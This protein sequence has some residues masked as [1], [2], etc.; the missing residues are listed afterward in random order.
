MKRILVIDDDSVM[1]QY[2]SLVLSENKYLVQSAST[3]KEGIKAAKEISPDLIICDVLLPDIDGFHVIKELQKQQLTKNVPVIFISA[4]KTEIDDIR[5]A[6]ELGADDYLI[7]P[8]KPEEILKSVEVRMKKY[9][10][11]LKAS[12]QESKKTPGS[13]KPI[14]K[15]KSK[16]ILVRG[17]NI[18]LIN[19]DKILYLLAEADYTKV[20]T[21]DGKKH[22]VS[23]LLK[24]WEEILPK[25]NFLRIHRSAIVNLD[26]VKKIEKWFNSAYRIYI[27]N[28]GE[29][30]TVSRRYVP[31]IK[32]YFLELPN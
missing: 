6:M 9:Q 8:F 28:T 31:K 4:C 12:K 22:M 18:E 21:D 24:K 13:K 5:R 3:G 32:S 15:E 23:R 27:Q 30:L 25:E 2:L 20:F 26:Y 1:C 17:G 7:K 19:T 10:E 16:W 14:S 11:L 29:P